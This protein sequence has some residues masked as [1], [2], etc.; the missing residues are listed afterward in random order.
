MEIRVTVGDIAQIETDAIVVNPFEG[1]QQPGGAT[2]TLA[3]SEANSQEA[4]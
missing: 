4:T 1:A 3:L 2:A